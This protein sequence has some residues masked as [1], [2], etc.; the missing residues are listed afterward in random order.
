[1]ILLYY[2]ARGIKTIVYVVSHHL[3]SI[4]EPIY[5]QLKNN[6]KIKFFYS[7]SLFDKFLKP[8]LK[9]WVPPI[10]S[11]LMRYLIFDM[12]ITP[13]FKQKTWFSKTLQT[14]HGTGVYN[15][16]KTKDILKNYDI[17]FAV[18]PQFNKLLDDIY[19]NNDKKYKVY[20]IGFPKTDVLL[21]KRN[22][23]AQMPP[24]IVVYAPHWNPYG[25]LH[26][27]GEHIIE[28][29]ARFNFKILVKPHQYIFKIYSKL[30]FEKRLKSIA[31]KYANVEYIEDLNTQKL[32]P[33]ADLMITDTGTTAGLEYSLLGKPLFLFYNKD[34]FRNNKY[35]YVEKD[36]CK[37]S[38]CFS[39]LN[40]LSRLINTITGPFMKKRLE[41]QKILQRKLIKKYLYNPGNATEKA[42]DAIL[43]ELGINTK[44]L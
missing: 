33:L 2:K 31:D 38:I 43:K 19:P 20:N 14:Y 1:L 16:Y 37:T 42:V 40:Q 10:S 35:G 21:K 34:W 26:I 29:L 3:Y 24:K 28:T 44:Q 22:K 11:R 17:H 12:V 7:G 27:F 4:I 25:S 15:S 39:N 8:K 13:D 5:N 6:K 30:N 9:N 23:S 36:I 18:G 41:K 32:Y